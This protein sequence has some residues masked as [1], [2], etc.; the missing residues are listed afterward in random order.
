MG[1]P[2]ALRFTLDGGNGG[3]DVE[4]NGLNERLTKEEALRLAWIGDAVLLLYARQRILQAEGVRNDE[5]CVRMTSNQFLGGVG[6][7]TRVEAEIG[8]RYL[9]NGWDA[10]C[11]WIDAH[12][13]PLHERQEL[14]Y[15][16]K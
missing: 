9:R 2:G 3:S 16:R 1:G 10:A 12:L 13:M 7:P 11:Q 4:N 8:R 5:R 14:K 6:E 15:A